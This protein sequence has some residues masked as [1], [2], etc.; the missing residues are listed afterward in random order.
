MHLQIT[1]VFCLITRFAPALNYTINIANTS[2]K[3][4]RF[5]HFPLFVLAF[6]RHSHFFFS[7]SLS[8]IQRLLMGL[9]HKEKWLVVLLRSYRKLILVN[10]DTCY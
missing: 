8:P 9:F 2:S 5:V 3:L 1:F 7:L 6:A 10:T 4:S